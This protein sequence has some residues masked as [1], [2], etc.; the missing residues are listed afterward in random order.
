ME[1]SDKKTPEIRVC[2]KLG[3][4]MSAW[5]TCRNTGSKISDA[6][7][8]SRYG[9]MALENSGKVTTGLF[10]IGSA[11][12]CT[13]AINAG[14]WVRMTAAAFFIVGD[15]IPVLFAKGGRTENPDQPAT[16]DAQDQLMDWKNYIKR[17]LNPREYPFEAS[18]FLAYIGYMIWNFTERFPEKLSAFLDAIAMAVM[19]VPER[20]RDTEEQQT[21]GAFDHYRP[22]IDRTCSPRIAKALKKTLLYTEQKPLTVAF[23]MFALSNAW[24]GLSIAMWYP[25]DGLVWGNWSA[26]ASGVAFG[27]YAHARDPLT[28]R[29][30]LVKAKA[31]TPKP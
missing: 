12:M 23:G 3:F 9:S 26:W 11:L 5:M 13:S 14:E 7:A 20:N 25:S 2:A 17:F 16:G 27:I 21:R 1:E 28:K 31:H 10:L 6:F 30:D 18:V 8:N 4:A 15:L 29:R 24:Y 19:L 22:A